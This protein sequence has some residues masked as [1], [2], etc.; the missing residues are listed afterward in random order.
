MSRVLQSWQASA[1][2]AGSSQKPP[3]EL[4]L[5]AVDSHPLIDSLFPR[6][7]SNGAQA[8]CHT[9]SRCR[10]YSKLMSED[11]AATLTQ[12]KAH[13]AELFDPKVAQYNG[14]IIKLIGDGSLVE[15]G[16]VIDAVNCAV[17]IQSSLAGADGPIRLR[18]G[19]N[20]GDVIIDGEDIYGDGVNI[21]AR[22]ESLANPNGICISSV[23][24]ES[25][26]NNIDVNFADSGEHQVKNITRPIRVFRWP[27]LGAS[28]RV[29][30]ELIPTE[31]THDNTISVA[32]FENLS[33]DA[34]LGYFCEA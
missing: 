5:N 23:V 14:R 26:G 21:A 30:R 9:R 25:L 13:R 22:L 15:F 10:R 3:F 18:I 24:H 2:Q 11:E 28:G 17:D 32:H 12:L 6:G 8:C 19:I 16:S 33:N 7:G 1:P 4:Q 34:E 27:A 31:L 20:L 29:S